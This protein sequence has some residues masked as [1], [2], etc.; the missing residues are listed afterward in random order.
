MSYMGYVRE[1]GAGGARNYVAVVASVIC[2]TTPVREIGTAFPEA[3]PVV[4]QYGCGQMGDDLAQTRRTLVGVAANPNV[5]AALVVGLGCENNQAPVL[6]QSIQAKKPIQVIGIQELGSSEKTVQVGIEIVEQMI[7]STRIERSL[8]QPDHLTVG[9]V[10]V[11]PDDEA[12]ATVFPAV[13]R[14]VDALVTSGA[15]VI[16]GVGAGLAPYGASLADRARDTQTAEGLARM[17]EGLARRRW[18]KPVDGKLNRRPW[19]D[20]EVA[21]AKLEASISG[22]VLIDAVVDY[23][24]RSTARGL[25]LMTVPSNP[26]EAMTGLVAGGAS[27][28]IAASA[29]GLLT[30]ALGAPTIVVAPTRSGFDPFD[31]FI[32]LKLMSDKAA[33]TDRVLQ[34]LY[35]VA[36]GEET[37][38]ER[39]RLSSFAISQVG[40]PF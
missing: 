1:T 33:E 36:S 28:I 34:K 2:S 21:R 31:E 37:L 3:L 19:T 25:T 26:V 18:Q 22:S 23:S 20:E 11:E 32:D 4:H 30:G 40:T 16:L 8:L 5:A 35:A 15:R 39:Q 12:L 9:V 38:T 14:A 27:V 29:R 13:G 24:E 10:G 6:A 7:R 17:G